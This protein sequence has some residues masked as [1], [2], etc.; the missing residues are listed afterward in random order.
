MRQFSQTLFYSD[1]M[2]RYAAYSHGQAWVYG[3]AVVWFQPHDEPLIK[4][5]S[6][7][8]S[9]HSSYHSGWFESGEICSQL[10]VIG[11]G[12]KAEALSFIGQFDG[13]FIKDP[14]LFRAASEIELMLSSNER[15]AI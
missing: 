4:P 14:A 2:T 11:E 9:D 5:S 3:R 12:S 13:G 8:G 1:C 6:V 15:M 10:D 7:G